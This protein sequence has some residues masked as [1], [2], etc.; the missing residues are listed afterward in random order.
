MIL[1]NLQ[2]EDN[3]NSWLQEP[4]KRY[5]RDGGVPDQSKTMATLENIENCAAIA[6]RDFD[7]SK[8][9]A[10]KTSVSVDLFLPWAFLTWQLSP[11]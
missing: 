7:I 2:T 3:P 4:T 9:L 1:E 10:G 8:S 6:M 11:T 5:L